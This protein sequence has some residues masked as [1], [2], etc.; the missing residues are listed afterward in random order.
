MTLQLD[1]WHAVGL[2]LGF[3]GFAFGM[4]KMLLLQA[5]KHQDEKHAQLA[6][7]L[8]K[9]EENGKAE[10]Q[11]WRQIERDLNKLQ[12]HLPLHYVRRE[13]YIRGQSVIEAKLDGLATKLENAQL[14]AHIG[15]N[16]S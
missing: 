14:R 9:I 5:Q 16:P 7:R 11:Q 3:L 1:F 15:G 8:T 12:M 4:A 2:L 6:V 10:A 13:D